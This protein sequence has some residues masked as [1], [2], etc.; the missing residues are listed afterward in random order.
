MPADWQPLFVNVN[1][2]TNEGIMHK[3]KPYFT[4]QFHPEANG[5]PADTAF[6]FDMFLQ[7]IKQ[8]VCVLSNV[9]SVYAV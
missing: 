3:S 2:G 1:D 7:T 5:G 9:L 6:L 4:A 8:K